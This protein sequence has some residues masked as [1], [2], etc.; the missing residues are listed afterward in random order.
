M[1]HAAYPDSGEDLG[2]P[3][4]TPPDPIFPCRTLRPLLPVFGGVAT[5]GIWSR[6]ERPLE[7]ALGVLW[8]AAGLRSRLRPYRWTSLHYGRIALNA[9]GY[10]V[11]G[12]ALRGVDPDPALVPPPH[13]RVRIWLDD[14]RRRFAPWRRR[15]VRRRARLSAREA[16]DV[17][18][19]A[20]KKVPEDLEALELARGPLDERTWRELL[21]LWLGERLLGEGASEVEAWARQ[22]L[23][24]ERRFT[25]VFGERLVERGDFRRASDA[26]YLTF[27]ERL[28][29]ATDPAGPWSVHLGTRTR[30]VQEFVGV[31]MPEL[32]WGSP[33]VIRAEKR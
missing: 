27:E 19:R 31:G 8:D 17:L 20:A 26:A 4:S 6:L 11:L 13:G 12:A 23:D 24:L 32:F 1:R 7:A 3:T 25:R 16:A 18:T 29:V 33:R 21:V 30:R 22:A 2:Y 5:P 14:A 15:G 10:E 9:H 28:V